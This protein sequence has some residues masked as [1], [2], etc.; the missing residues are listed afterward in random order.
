MIFKIIQW[1]IKGFLNNYNELRMLIKEQ[2]PTFLCLQE[3]HCLPNFCPN[4]P[5]NY[6]SYFHNIPQNTTSKQG[7]GV[8]IKTNIPHKIVQIN[9]HLQIIA[10]E[11][12]LNPKFTIINCY[13]PPNQQI[14]CQHLTN[15][16]ESIQTPVVLLGDFNSWNPLWGSPSPN[17]RGKILEN[18]INEA[19]LCILNDGRPTHL[20]THGTLTHLDIT[21]CTPNF[22]PFITWKVLDDL[23]HSDHFPVISTITLSQTNTTHYTARKF[24]CDFADWVKF[25]QTVELELE[26]R[27][28]SDN[29]NKEANNMTK[30]I[31][32]AA[33]LCIPQ[34]SNRGRK[35]VPWWNSD[36]SIL[37]REKMA[38]WHS[39][40]RHPTQLNLLEYKKRNAIFRREMKQQK[41]SSFENFAKTININ[42]SPQELWSKV[43]RLTNHNT[44]YSIT[45]IQTPQHIITEPKL[46]AHH[47]AQN[48]SEYSL[49]CNFPNQ[50]RQEKSLQQ[51]PNQTTSNN[52]REMEAD[53]TMDELLCTLKTTKGKTPGFD[54]ISY[55][56]IKHL[57]ISTKTRL[58]T[59][60]N[61]ILS[62]G[63][64]P[65]NWKAATIIPVPKR[66]KN[67]QLA[68]SYRPIS[69]IS[70]LSKLVEKIIAT[71]LLWYTEKMKLISSNQ[72]GFRPGKGCIDA[73][74]HIDCHVSKALST[75]NHTSIL[76]I[77][78]EKA[79]DRIGSHV[80]LKT[81]HQWK[82][83]PKI[84]GFI[85]AFLQH[86]K[87]RARVNGV[88]S[89]L[90]P[91]VNGIP[92]GSPLSVLLFSI[93]FNELS[94]ILSKNNRISHCI[95]A[96]DLYILSNIKNNNESNHVLENT[97]KEIEKW[98]LISGA[99][100]SFE[101][102]K[103]LHI[104]KKHQ[105]NANNY[106]ITL[107]TK[108]IQNVAELRVLGLIFTHNYSWNRQLSTLKKALLPR[109]NLISYLSYK[110]YVH[111]NTLIH[112]IKTIIIS[113][114]DYGLFLY[115]S[116]S[117]TSLN[118]IKSTYHKAIRTALFAFRTTPL[119][120]M[121]IESGLP[122]LEERI[123]TVR[124]KL[125]PKI[126]FQ[127]NSIIDK[128]AKKLASNKRALRTSPVI[129]KV[130]Q[131]C[132]EF[133][134]AP[135]LRT[136]KIHNP[137]WNINQA[138][139]DFS[140]NRHKKDITP[141]FTFKQLFL[142]KSTDLK[143]NGWT[144]IYTDG[145]KTNSSTAFSVTTE[146]GS[147]LSIKQMFPL[148]SIF[149]A[150][151][152]AILEALELYTR[153]KQKVAI[154]SDSLSVIRAV[155]NPTCNSW[156]T[157]NN[158]RDILIKNTNTVKLLWIPGHADIEG[159]SHADE[160]AKFACNAPII[161]A[162]NIEKTDIKH[163][164]QKYLKEKS[165]TKLQNYQH[166]HYSTINRD[167]MPPQYPTNVN[168]F[169]TRIFSRLRLGHTTQTHVYLLKQENQTLCENCNSHQ[170]LQHILNE[171]PL[172][173]EARQT[174][175]DSQNISEILST[176]TTT[177]IEKIAKFVKTINLTI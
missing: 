50:F 105:C 154:C 90:Y 1:N 3:T 126:L 95:Y 93:A 13:I 96:D 67:N 58:L 145:S 119:T 136:I 18:V 80:I 57:N 99:K 9:T 14:P 120:N 143:S 21:C 39:F 111:I 5:K 47:F 35:H 34:S 56:M 91:L 25:S 157:I 168:G 52:A 64:I 169:K 49:D 19:D 162:P 53:I 41:K 107:Q 163:H 153:K 176:P 84:F 63:I 146:S 59:L 87:I 142:Q 74:L 83:G 11:I 60:Y 132:S 36:L 172:Y 118:T 150:E 6:L 88:Y 133:S 129:A 48:W 29:P 102:T 166:P 130:L 135:N 40:R 73:L 114:I 94:S 160:A 12:N 131:L 138:S 113:K 55:N 28:Y 31:R 42:T 26:K 121:L 37:R 76:S 77:D 158:I 85:K 38:A 62:T 173:E 140:L 123:H 134:I 7:V 16:L 175:L 139:C 100:I 110:G 10:V 75:R 30:A 148:C 66:Q 82:V 70:C 112:L 103:K 165:K 156:E 128:D 24:L 149:S 54:R 115:G 97:L 155:R 22:L 45:A 147:F 98:T 23:Y 127:A 159:N 89:S 101:K 171:C 33:N 15:I 27:P 20:S 174:I 81:L 109:V 124:A 69:L 8:L 79:F 122:K 167:R 104:C 78:F 32:T 17:S 71:R 92:Q 43:K 164:I 152:T 116:A 65:Q 61:D 51:V 137:P 177:N 86:R 106:S 68:G 108:T 161:T 44:Q 144:I 46:I 2:N 125:I 151:A 72:V 170:T 141:N 4:T 117:K